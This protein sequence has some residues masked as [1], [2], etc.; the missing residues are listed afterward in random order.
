MSAT[1]VKSEPPHSREHESRVSV[2]ALRYVAKLAG[3]LLGLTVVAFVLQIVS[4]EINGQQEWLEFV[5][6]DVVL[7]TGL[8]LFAKFFVGTAR[9]TE[10]SVINR[11]ISIVLGDI[12]SAATAARVRLCLFG[13]FLAAAI[14]CLI[15]ASPLTWFALSGDDTSHGA[16]WIHLPNGMKPE[17]A[18]GGA[19]HVTTTWWLA[20]TFTWVSFQVL[21]ANLLLQAS[22]QFG[23]IWSDGTARVLLRRRSWRLFSD[24]NP[25]KGD[26]APDEVFGA[27]A[28]PIPEKAPAT[29][30]DGNAN[31]SVCQTAPLGVRIAH[32]SDLHI[33]CG[34]T[35]IEDQEA[36]GAKLQEP[37]PDRVFEQCLSRLAKAEGEFDVLLITGDVTDRGSE[38]QWAY[39][40]KLVAQY[41]DIEKRVIVLPGNHDTN[42]NCSD[43]RVIDRRSIGRAHKLR[44]LLCTMAEIHEDRGE[45]FES[46]DGLIPIKRY[47]D[48][49]IQKIDSLDDESEAFREGVR[50]AWDGLFPL[51]VRTSEK[52]AVVGLDSVGPSS[53]LLSNA[54]GRIDSEALG[55]LSSL[56]VLLFGMGYSCVYAM[57]HQ[58]LWPQDLTA[59]A[60]AQ[61]SLRE[62]MFRQFQSRFMV[63][64]DAPKLLSVLD[65]P[66]R[67]TVLFHGHKHIG[68]V[69]T[70][71]ENL[72]VAS[73]ASTT[74]GDETG[75]NGTDGAGRYRLFTITSKPDGGVSASWR[76]VQPIAEG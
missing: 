38:Q 22:W 49:A 35:R 63:V 8:Y 48:R 50:E 3:V 14:G 24:R 53:H 71:G 32:W 60:K 34:E 36:G 6:D 73:A 16:S 12:P 42:I 41:S 15:V 33:Q 11:T 67:T 64:E 76:M 28:S 4:R 2:A 61:S 20:N 65:A 29:A 5:I 44:N 39:F 66:A 58:L 74:Y 31:D 69:R 75:R 72:M 37:N 55:R 18:P 70:V 68:Y 27:G 56:Q 62:K 47:V 26:L 9:R 52:V 59:M 10:A 46:R 17:L 43:A 54:F 1:R 21:F 45:V 51:V 19:V 40:R 57:H 25:Y 7:G 23:T 30:S 13:A